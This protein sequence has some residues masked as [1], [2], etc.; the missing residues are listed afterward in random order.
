MRNALVWVLYLFTTYYDLA[1]GDFGSAEQTGRLRPLLQI[2]PTCRFR[3]R[4]P[5]DLIRRLKGKLVSLRQLV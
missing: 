4:L 3:L 5:V 1:S 2:H